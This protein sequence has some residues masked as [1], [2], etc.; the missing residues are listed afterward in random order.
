M[1]MLKTD[2]ALLTWTGLLSFKSLEIL[3]RIVTHIEKKRNITLKLPVE[4]RIVLTLMVIRH[5]IQFNMLAVLFNRSSVTISSNFRSTIVTLSEALSSIIYWPPNE[6]NKASMPIYF[7]S[8]FEDTKIVLDCTECKIPL[9]K[10]L[11]CR[12][13]SYSHY[14]SNHTVKYLIGVTPCGTIC[15]VSPGYPGRASDKFI[16]NNEKVIDL[17]NPDTDAVMTDKGFA[18]EKELEAKGKPIFIDFY[19]IARD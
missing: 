1:D 11:K 6:E 14:K 12:L 8:F 9:L 5:N 17:L 16:F 18:I 7:M 15:Y 2:S 13:A 10:C 4:D 3:E 19:K